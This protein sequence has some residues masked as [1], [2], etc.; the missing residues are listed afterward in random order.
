MPRHAGPDEVYFQAVLPKR[1]VYF[2]KLQ[3]VER[4]V[5]MRRLVESILKDYLIR[6]GVNFDEQ[7][8]KTPHGE[9]R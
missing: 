6:T 1:V 4:G 9:K 2:L 3:A 7:S 5:P 8:T